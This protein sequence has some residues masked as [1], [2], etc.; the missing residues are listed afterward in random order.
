MTLKDLTELK[1][2]YDCT[3]TRMPPDYVVRT[4]YSDKTANGL[5]KAIVAFIKLNGGM[6]ERVKNTGRYIDESKVVTDVMGYTKR[7]GSGKYITGTGT[8][9]SADI[10]STIRGRTV[11]IEVKIGADKQSDAQKEYQT[12][13][14]RAGGIYMIAKTFDNFYEQYEKIQN[15]NN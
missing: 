9:G 4:K 14:E 3:Q 5:E 2:K 8:N 13:I 1:W 12:M 6:A 10:H 7:I 11:A 15:N